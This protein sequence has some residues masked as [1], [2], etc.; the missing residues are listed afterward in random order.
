LADK[1]A[2]AITRMVDTTLLPLIREDLLEE[3]AHWEL[4]L[5]LYPLELVM[6]QAV[7]ETKTVAIPPNY[8][9]SAAGLY[10]IIN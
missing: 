6:R 8:Q 1:Y 9:Q 10:L 3:Y 4:P 5:F 2:D 7:F